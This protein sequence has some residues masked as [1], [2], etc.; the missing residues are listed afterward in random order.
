MGSLLDGLGEALRLLGG[1]DPALYGII[2]RTLLISGTATVLA[3][4]AGVPLGYALARSR[5]R[6]RAARP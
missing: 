5:F 6:G 2:G 3:M 4:L 1:G